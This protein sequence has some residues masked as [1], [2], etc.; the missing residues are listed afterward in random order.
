MG[1]GGWNSDPHMYRFLNVGSSG[2]LI[3]M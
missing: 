1:D 2:D 3:D